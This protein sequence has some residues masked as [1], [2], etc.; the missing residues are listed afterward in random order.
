MIENTEDPPSMT[1]PNPDSDSESVLTD[2]STKPSNQN[3]NNSNNDEKPGLLGWIKS[4]L[5]TPKPDSSLRETIEEFIEESNSNTEEDETVASFHEK[6][7][8]SNVLKLRD[9]PV[10]D[11]MIPRADIVAID[12][13]ASEEELFGL[14][15][16]TQYSRIPVFNEKLDDVMGSLHIKDVLSMLSQ[17]KAVVIKDL[18]R[19]VPIISPSMNVLDLLLK[20]RQTRKHMAMVVDEFGG[21]DGLVTIG[22]IIEEIVGELEDEHDT[23][24]PPQIIK[25]DDGSLVAD[26]RYDLDEFEEEYGKHLSEEEREENDTLG[27]LVFFM[28]GRVPARGEV[29]THDTGMVFEILDADP[30]RVTRIKITHIPSADESEAG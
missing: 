23:D 20:M 22:D 7:L 29:L 15:S 26:A 30:R 16:D 21:I 17:K 9:K 14:L 10:V 19:D 13:N 2:I 3:G 4:G 24:A 6:T 5:K 25:S 18:M 11:A 27:G 28:A 1:A 12:V 8:I